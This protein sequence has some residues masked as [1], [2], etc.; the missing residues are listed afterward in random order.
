M[1]SSLVIL[2]VFVTLI[3]SA[4]GSS[5]ATA[6]PTPMRDSAVAP[7]PIQQ[8]EI[9]HNMGEEQTGHGTELHGAAYGGQ[10]GMAM[11]A[12]AGGGDFHLEIVSDTPGQYGVYLSDENRQP[13][14][15]EGYEG[16]LAIIRPNGSEIARM[17]LM[18]T[19][20]HLQAKGGPTDVSQVDVRITLKGPGLSDIV[21]MDFTIPYTKK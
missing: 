20:D 13:V 15:L 16:T 11:G 3:I 8:E 10:V 1:K 4:C 19:G 18:V 17:P 12:A 9:E 2:F 21:E 14:S 7:T 6:P 5:Q